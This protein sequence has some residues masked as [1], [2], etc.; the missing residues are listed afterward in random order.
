MTITAIG[1]LGQDLV[2]MAR[3]FGQEEQH[4]CANI[5][6]FTATTTRRTPRT[7]T[8]PRPLTTRSTT[9]AMTVVASSAAVAAAFFRCLLRLWGIGLSGLGVH[10]SP[11]GYGHTAVTA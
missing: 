11:H 9:I 7:A 1:K 4:R 3:L 2:P 6:A 10:S 5:A 8:T